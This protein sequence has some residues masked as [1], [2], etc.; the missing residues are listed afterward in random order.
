MNI[1]LV[2]IN[3][4]YIHT[5]L[6]VRILKRYAAPRCSSWI[7]T[8]EYTINQYTD[9][10][11]RDI[12]LKKPDMIGFSCYL[13]NITF[14]QILMDA[15]KK[16]LSNC[17]LFVGGPETSFDSTDVLA[18][19]KADF[20]IRGE[21]EIPFT[22][23]VLALEQGQTLEN[24]R[25]ITWRKP[26]GEIIE[27][28]DP[29][30]SIDMADVPFV[31]TK[32]EL[33]AHQIVYY[34]AT[35]GCPFSCQYCLSGHNS[36][37]RFRPLTQVYEDLSFFLSENVP[38]VKFVDRTFNC[39]REYAMAIWTYLREHDNGVTNFHFEMA[40]EL[41][42]KE[43]IEWLSD[44]RPGLFQFEIGVQSTNP[45]TLKAVKRITLPDK[46]T[47][48]ITALKQPQNIHLHLDLIAGLPFEGY[49]RFKESFNY[50]Y[51]L[52]PDQ[53]QL[54]FLKLL[55][56]SGLYQNR[57]QYGLVCRSDAPYEILCTP[58]ISFDELLRLKRIAEMVELYY[59]TLRYRQS[60]SA[61]LSQFSTPFDCFEALADFYE[62]NGYH[63]APHTK[64]ENYTILFRF[65]ESIAPE[66]AEWFSWILR[67]DLYA[68]E[69]A[70]KL[71]PFMDEGK[72][73]EY[74]SRI[75]SFFDDPQARAAYLPEYAEM[76]TRQIIRSAHIEVFP[77]NPFTHTPG[78]TAVLFNYRRL[79]FD[80]NASA[81]M[82][83]L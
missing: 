24:V 79:T 54:G 51:S 15:L 44:V 27:N 83:S 61:L 4:K 56:G 75:Y 9:D 64:L 80:K 26:T 21:G 22:E 76:D 71:P 73:A 23:A 2:G 72:K 39:N 57:E 50:V 53:L 42:D 19:T 34:E 14:V 6:A 7:E 68:H 31:Y 25:G 8:A 20:V 70:K 62:A 43:M 82:I 48:V 30:A 63:L 12:Y 11:L 38:Q 41:I 33:P 13:W 49:D 78:D 66:R 32:E 29:A 55:K 5:N 52:S 3:T 28:P 36:R 18:R 81:V 10:I 40:A 46:L 58:W 59:N 47:P 17:I 1:L 77:F 65:Y 16:V 69:K 37:V 45:E 60:L 74:H 35:R 67:F